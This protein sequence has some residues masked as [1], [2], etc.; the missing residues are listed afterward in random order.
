MVCNLTAGRKMWWESGAEGQV[1]D[2]AP[3]EW[4]TVTTL[5]ILYGCWCTY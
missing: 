3:G 1:P 4:G 2:S 5:L